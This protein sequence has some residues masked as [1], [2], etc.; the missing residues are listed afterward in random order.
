[1]LMCGFKKKKRSFNTNFPKV[2]ADRSNLCLIKI[3]PEKTTLSQ[4]R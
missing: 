4:V 2:R 3:T 1:M